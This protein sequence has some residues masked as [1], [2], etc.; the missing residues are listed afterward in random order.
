MMYSLFKIMYDT[1]YIKLIYILE[2]DAYF[3]LEIIAR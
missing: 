3:I 2:K 1:D